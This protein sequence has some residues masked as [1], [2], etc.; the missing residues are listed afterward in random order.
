MAGGAASSNAS[1]QRKRVEAESASLKRARDGSAFT[2]CEECHKDVAV[3]LI[4]FH[5]CSLDA[6]IK[7]NLESQVVEMAE[8]KKKASAEKKKTKQTDS[9]PKK[10]KNP[11]GKKRPPTAFFLFM[12]DFRKS[13]KE[14][15]P[16]CKSV[17]T[18]AKEGGEK[19]KS[20]NDGEK[21]VYTDRAAEL[22]AEYQKA[23]E[24]ENEHDDDDSTENEVK[25]D[26]AEDE[27]KDD[28]A[29]D[30]VKDDEA[31]NEVKH[32]TKETSE[33]EIKDDITDEEIKEEE[34]EDDE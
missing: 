28:A 31:E 32:E 15:N 30:E 6:K 33:K 8:T 24:A 21:K 9:K 19:W 2:K 14:A 10:A 25:D 27:V 16:D 26:T 20:M 13:F 3:A 4:S 18:V 17:A 22:K 5:N 7:M 23:T 1:R 29:E 12:N 34:I 11:N